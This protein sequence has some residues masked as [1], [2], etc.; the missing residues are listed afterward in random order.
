MWHAI[1]FFSW[2][3]NIIIM[4]KS[5]NLKSVFNGYTIFV[6]KT[7]LHVYS[8]WIKWWNNNDGGNHNLVH[9]CIYI[10]KKI[11]FSKSKLKGGWESNSGTSSGRFSL[12]IFYKKICINTTIKQTIKR[13][14][15]ALLKSF[16]SRKWEYKIIKNRQSK[17]ILSDANTEVLQK[18]KKVNT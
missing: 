13:Y 6:R 18:R 3:I 1:Y 10:N 4:V 8:Y 16:K 5:F 15:N 14:A 9:T 11:C 12:H 17:M 2:A 7:V